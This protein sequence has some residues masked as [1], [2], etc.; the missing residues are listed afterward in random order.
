[1][2]VHGSHCCKKHG[3]KYC[4][5]DCPVVLG[6]EEQEYRQICCDDEDRYLKDAYKTILSIMR[7]NNIKILTADDLEKMIASIKVSDWY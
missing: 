7:K 2:S 1:M 3:C 4:D 5:D 6:T